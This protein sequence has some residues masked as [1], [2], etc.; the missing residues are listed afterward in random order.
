MADRFNRNVLFTCLGSPGKPVIDTAGP[1]LMQPGDRVMLCSDGLWGSLSDTDIAQ[2]LADRTISD[3]VP[4]LVERALRIAGDKSDNV[5]VLAV[6]FEAAELA[7]GGAG[8]STA[9][10]GDEVFAS[11]IQ[12]SIG[13]D[14]SAEELDEAE[15]ERSI[16][17]INEAI[18]RS[19]H[20][21]K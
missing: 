9:S 6:E 7:E 12:A 10:L 20:K 4:E 13:G 17:E 3:A 11:T 21:R 2:I 5:T 15:I 8:V 16:R 1:L 18:Q 14:A 19:S